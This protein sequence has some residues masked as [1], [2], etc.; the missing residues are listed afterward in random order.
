MARIITKP[1]VA[2]FCDA[3]IG[4]VCFS[5][6]IHPDHCAQI[7]GDGNECVA[8]WAKAN[9]IDY[10]DYKPNYKVFQE[11]AISARNKDMIDSVDFVIAFW[12]NKGADI[13]QALR[14]AATI[15]RPYLCHSIIDLKQRSSDTFS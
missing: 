1:I 15:N 7:I 10:I 3:S 6:F 9:K 11:H 13:P 2:I 4:D 8:Q 12:D 5:R 14:Y